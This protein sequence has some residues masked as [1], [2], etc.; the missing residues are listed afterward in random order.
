MK[1]YI[2]KTFIKNLILITNITQFI[3]QYIDLKKKNK[4]YYALCPF[5]T[6]S[7]P[8]FIVNDDKQFY[9]C[10]GCNEHGNVIDFLMK[11]NGLD[12]LRSI[13][14]LALFNGYKDIPIK[15][16]KIKY[17]YNINDLFKLI[18]NVGKFY[19]KNLYNKNNYIAYNYLINRKL[20]INI[21]NFFEIGFASNNNNIINIFNKNKNINLELLKTL[22][23]VTKYGNK[24]LRDF[25]KNRIIFPIKNISGQIVG[26]GGRSINNNLPKYM[27]TIDNFIFSKKNNLYGLYEMHK[28]CKNIK[29]II[30]VE[31]Y[32]DVLTL[33]QHG[34]YNV[35]ST[36]GN[37]INK[38]Q[39]NILFRNSKNIVCCYDG[40]QSGLNA[41]WNMLKLSL[42]YMKDGYQLK[43]IFLPLKEDPDSIIM[44][45]GIL[46]FKKI[47]SNAEPLSV[48][49]FKILM[50]K[51]NCNS[52]ES[53]TK[54][55][56]LAI[57]LINKIPSKTLRFS[58]RKKLGK[59]LNIPEE[60][61][62]SL[63]SKDFIYNNKSFTKV[64][65]SNMKLLISLLIQNPILFKSIPNKMLHIFNESKILGIPFFIDLIC[66]YNKN[67]YITT[68]QLIEL[69]RNTKYE[70]IIKLL[71]IWDN[72]ISS[73]L[74]KCVF[75]DIF[76]NLCK[77]ELEI[78]IN[79]LIL[80][81]RLKGLDNKQRILLWYFT[82][83]L[84]EINK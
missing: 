9:Y 64:K 61:L 24:I 71:S 54:I 40:D 58:L 53:L 37:N 43:F 3:N 70:K 41:A 25:F 17:K 84:L 42:P 73:N 6:E 18:N 65:Y 34:I 32:I 44:K 29:N 63:I 8:S 23:L 56:I 74:I 22:G 75:I 1:E 27:N 57:P 55:N 20:N 72:M 39:I 69:Y 26:F 82:K 33:F 11:Y 51:I 76:Y 80:K 28:L 5:H 78:K 35:V 59:M 81:E 67:N 16:N 14:E 46:Y 48:F 12:F 36:L 13:K 77:Y 60:I 30:L 47:L 52:I 21:I 83:K 10:F 49:F 15:K 7:K 62:E 50:L 79:K 38:I 19:H 68:G 2:S 45:Y 66:N 4:Y 31:G